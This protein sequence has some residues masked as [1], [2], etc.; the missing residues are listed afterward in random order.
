MLSVL[1]SAL[2]HGKGAKERLQEN[3]EI[4]MTHEDREDFKNTTRCFM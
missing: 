4:D 1:F 2:K 3:K